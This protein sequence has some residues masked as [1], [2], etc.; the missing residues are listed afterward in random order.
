[1]QDGL[2]FEGQFLKEIGFFLNAE[3]GVRGQDV[4]AA[5]LLREANHYDLLQLL[6]L[7]R[8]RVIGEVEEDDRAEDLEFEV[9]SGENK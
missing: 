7:R 1:M 3:K 6:H 2:Y 9:V 4:E 5:M 8:V